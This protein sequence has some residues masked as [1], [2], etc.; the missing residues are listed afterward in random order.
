MRSFY[1]KHDKPLLCS[2]FNYSQ[3]YLSL[4][5]KFIYSKWKIYI[6]IHIPFSIFVSIRLKKF[7]KSRSK[8]KRRKLEEDRVFMDL[9]AIL[10][11]I[12][13]RRKNREGELTRSWRSVGGKLRRV[14]FGARIQE[15]WL[16]E[17]ELSQSGFS[18]V[19]P[20]LRA[21]VKNPL[22]SPPFTLSFPLHFLPAFL[23]FTYL[24]HF[25]LGPLMEHRTCT[26]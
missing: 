16:A 9:E 6:S 7:W 8:K 26:E 2:A 10:G 18:T 19:L 12:S 17:G 22:P 21:P 4:N 11:T 5:T 13:R 20:P 25:Y 14:S 23:A 15:K 1:R 24:L 3:P